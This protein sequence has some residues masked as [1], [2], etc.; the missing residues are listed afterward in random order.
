MN[1]KNK[2]KKKTFQG[3]RERATVSSEVKTTDKF[4]AASQF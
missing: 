4:S 2:K 1:T 3:E